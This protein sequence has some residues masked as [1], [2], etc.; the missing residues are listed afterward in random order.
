MAIAIG[1]FNSRI[2]FFKHNADGETDE[3]GYNLPD[4][5]EVYTCWCRPFT[6]QG[7]EFFA[8]AAVQAERNVR[9][10]IRFTNEVELTSNMRVEHEGIMYEIVAPPIN[11]NFKNETYTI[12]CRV[13]ENG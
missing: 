9:F 10:V 12:I 13:L 4:Y 1:E 8:A 5:S 6:L 11:D 3:D 2:T 7:R